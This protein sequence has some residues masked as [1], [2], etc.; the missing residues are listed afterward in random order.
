MLI[1]RLPGRTGREARWSWQCGTE[2]R[3][4]RFLGAAPLPAGWPAVP[5]AAT[6]DD[7]ERLALPRLD[8]ARG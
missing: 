5:L 6:I 4:S 8:A 3:R 2:D 7:V 1:I